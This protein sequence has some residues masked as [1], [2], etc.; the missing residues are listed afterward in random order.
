MSTTLAPSASALLV[1]G[2]SLL[3]NC[4]PTASTQAA[5]AP[6][7]NALEDSATVGLAA[8]HEPYFLIG[9]AVDPQ[10][11]ATHGELL[12]THFN[13]VTTENAM[14]FE[15]LQPT[16]G[17]FN[18][19]K[20]DAMLAAAKDNNMKARGHALVWHRQTP[21][22]V[23][24][25]P[26]G[27]AASKELLQQRME[28]HI[29]TVVEHF[30]GS[31]YAWDVVNEAILN[32]GSWRSLQEEKKI[33]QS[34]WH[35]I[36]GEDYVANAFRLA[37]EVDPNAKLFYND[38]YNYI[39]AKRDAIYEMIKS[40]LAAGV[41]IHGVGVQAHLGIE[42]SPLETHQG[43]L[44]TLENMSAAIERY[45]SLGLE[46]QITELDLSVYTPGVKLEPS[47]YYT[48]ETFTEALQAKQAQRYASFFQL[49]RDHA[50]AI[51]SVTFW[52]VADDNTWL[53]E[54]DSGRTDFPLLFDVKHAAKPAF[55][56][57]MN[58]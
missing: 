52:G 32:D 46:V 58:F 20:A 54:F 26:T 40:L 1:L 24:T 23:F 4:T 19:S 53:S 34:Q 13:S 9:A 8:K 30:K 3:A 7:S 36:L 44:Q 41:P 56:A 45:A 28:T 37:H 17:Q 6:S 35:A 12:K 38:Y 2:T 27:G 10:T 11:F 43:R 15:S 57:V 33:D 42:P 21:D 31:V 25:S 14:K 39:P 51:S 47:E 29:R 18:F 16:E 50:D 5:A 22:W 49:F 48:L 55:N